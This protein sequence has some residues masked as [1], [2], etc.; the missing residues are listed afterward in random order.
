MLSGFLYGDSTFFRIELGQLGVHLT[1]F[2]DSLAL[3]RELAVVR[4]RFVLVDLDLAGGDEALRA[5]A[6]IDY[7][8][9]LIV[10]AGKLSSEQISQYRD[11]GVSHFLIKPCHA[12]QLLATVETT[13]LDAL[14]QAPRAGEPAPVS[15]VIGVSETCRNIRDQAA[16]L[17]NSNLP[18][19]LQGESGVGKEVAA[20]EFHLRSVRRNK[21]FMPVNCST[22]GALVESE[23]FGHTRGAFTHAVRSTYGYVGAAEGGVLFLDEVGEL[24]TDVQAKLLRFLDSREYCKVGESTIRTADV[25]ILSATNRDLAEL[26]RQGRFR[27]DLYYRLSGVKVGIAPLR[28]RP[29][30]IPFLVWHFLDELYTDRGHRFRVTPEA[31][32]LLLSFDWPGNVRQ[33]RHLVYLV[34]ERCKNRLIDYAAIA[35]E[36]LQVDQGQPDPRQVQRYSQAKEKFLQDFER[37]YFLKVV[38]LSQ[39]SL[40]RA[41]DLT[42]MHKKNYYDK[43]HRLD[44]GTRRDN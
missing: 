2:T 36:L 9:H 25:R 43:L 19:L 15:V 22:L 3:Q 18:I 28:E 32:A 29:D 17:T 13:R 8:V 31:M 30:D 24:S 16:E 37:R 6:A 44:I 27:A 33:L 42:G 26:C 4:P 41:L 20:Q 14:E 23:L 39:G 11:L 10:L 34:S 21:P 38:A 40:K 5:V 1:R 12:G 35:R 7:R